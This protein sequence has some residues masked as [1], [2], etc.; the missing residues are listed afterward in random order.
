MTALDYAQ[1]HHR[2][3]GGPP[4]EQLTEDAASEAT[5]G[6]VDPR[7]DPVDSATSRIEQLVTTLD[8]ETR[9]DWATT[10]DAMDDM[11]RAFAAEGDAIKRAVTEYATKSV[12]LIDTSRVIR[13]AVDRGRKEIAQRKPATVTHIRERT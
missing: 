10:R 3:R 4:Q 13:D 12:A 8:E 9:K 5:H 7:P 2:K 1:P 11:M 6:A